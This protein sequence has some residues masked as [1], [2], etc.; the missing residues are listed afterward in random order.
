ML[1]EITAANKP[2]AQKPEI[3]AEEERIDRER[4]EEQERIYERKN[5]IGRG[6]S[7]FFAL[8]ATIMVFIMNYFD[9]KPLGIIILIILAF[10]N[11]IPFL[12]IFKSNS[13]DD[14]MRGIFLC[15]SIIISVL[16][17][18][19]GV[20]VGV[21]GELIASIGLGICNLASCIIAMIFPKD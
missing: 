10:I 6:I 18:I 9:T 2:A 15:I 1:R 19:G 7:V 12:V 14:I 20:L 16:V 4:R 21:L 11:L 13:Y 5:K 3:S 17:V 8:L